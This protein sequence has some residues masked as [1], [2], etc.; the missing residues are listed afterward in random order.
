MYSVI[1]NT[2]LRISYRMLGEW[3]C[4]G[5]ASTGGPVLQIGLTSVRIAHCHIPQHA[6]PTGTRL[7]DVRLCIKNLRCKWRCCC[8]FLPPSP[9]LTSISARNLIWNRLFLPLNENFHKS[10]PQQEPSPKS[11]AMRTLTTP[12]ASSSQLIMLRFESYSPTCKSFKKV[13]SSTHTE[14]NSSQVA[15]QP[16]G[17]ELDGNLTTTFSLIFP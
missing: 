14:H 9:L 5:R 15:H 17:F 16:E 2:L 11:S 8:T 12:C 6:S 4:L 7:H 3:L 13:P 1:T 10:L